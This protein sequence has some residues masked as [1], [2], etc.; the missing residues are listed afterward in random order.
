[1]IRPE[2]GIEKSQFQPIIRKNR[3]LNIALSPLKVA[4]NKY[5]NDKVKQS[6]T[7]LDAARKSAVEI[8]I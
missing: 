6:T 1:M 8:E 3:A 5:C 7:V 2:K 4:A